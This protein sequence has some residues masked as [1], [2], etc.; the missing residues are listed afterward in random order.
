MLQDIVVTLDHW[1]VYSLSRCVHT[2]DQVELD[3][4]H[5]PSSSSRVG[6]GRYPKSASTRAPK[7]ASIRI[8]RS[9][10][11]LVLCKVVESM[12]QLALCGVAKYELRL[13]LCRVVEL[14]NPRVTH[15]FFSTPPQAW[16][17]R[18]R[19]PEVCHELPKLVGS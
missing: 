6:F 16:Q 18:D 17:V 7:S 9:L 1:S 11:R 19:Q 8:N 3:F 5:A 14:R 13:A 4:Q 2:L 15:S 12:L 10:L